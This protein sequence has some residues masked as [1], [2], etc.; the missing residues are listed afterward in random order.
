MAPAQSSD[1]KATVSSA[2]RS[3]T[4]PP[5]LVADPAAPIASSRSDTHGAARGAP[6]AP[7][8]GSPGGDARVASVRWATTAPTMPQHRSP[9]W[10][11]LERFAVDVERRGFDRIWVWDHLVWHSPVLEC[12]ESVERVLGSTTTIAAGP[13]VL[14]APLRDPQDVLERLERLTAQ[15]GSRLSL[16]IGA[17]RRREEFAALGQPFDERWPRTEALV[18]R[19]ATAEAPTPV[20]VGG[21]SPRARRLA[22]TAGGWMPVFADPDDVAAGAEALRS[23]RPDAQVVSVV[24]LGPFGN[25]S[26]G[27]EWFASLY[28]FERFPRT[29][30]LPGDP[31]E[32]REAIARYA[33][34]GSDEIC[35]VV[36]DDDPGPTIEWFADLIGMEGGASGDP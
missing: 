14:Q 35:V 33:E 27:A 31:N 15:F 7:A 17:G 25:R 21:L 5:G 4:V 10:A 6:I 34:A 28:G 3:V 18:S 19:L 13:G 11:T 23:Q 2:N 20:F 26:Q 24:A 29:R 8:V 12:L 1:V 22:A 32:L 30:V 9:D 36:A 16:G